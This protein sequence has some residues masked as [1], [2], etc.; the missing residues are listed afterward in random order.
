MPPA[1]PKPDPTA[2]ATP[3]PPPHH[4]DRDPISKDTLFRIRRDGT[5]LAAC[6]PLVTKEITRRANAATSTT[7]SRVRVKHHP[8][9]IRKASADGSHGRAASCPPSVDARQPSANRSATHGGAGRSCLRPSTDVADS[10]APAS[11]Q[12]TMIGRYAAQERE[13]CVLNCSPPA[14]PPSARNRRSARYRAKSRVTF[15][16]QRWS[17]SARK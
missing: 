11:A 17:A 9:T 10:N 4:Q 6:R 14:N 5:Q 1:R 2:T 8:T 7:T 12:D 15:C 13:I 16:Q 3:V